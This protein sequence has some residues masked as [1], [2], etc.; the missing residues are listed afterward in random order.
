MKKG[1]GIILYLLF[2]GGLQAQQYIIR[3]DLAG[4]NVKYLQVKKRGD[5]A[6][7]SIIRFSQTNQ[8]NLQLVNSANSYRREITYINRVETPEAVI[9]PG[10][11]STPMK[12]TEAGLPFLDTKTMKTGDIFK[13]ANDNKG[14]E[15][16]AETDQQ[17]VLQQEFV[18][19]YNNFATAYESW[20]Q[21]FYF[22]QNCEVLWKDLAGLRYDMQFPAEEIKKTARKK[23]Q[24]VFPGINDNPAA[25]LSAANTMNP[26]T[27]AAAVKTSYKALTDAHSLFK[28]FDVKSGF[29][30]SLVSSAT[31]K[32]YAVSNA[33]AVKNVDDVVGRITNLYRQIVNDN[34][35]YMTPLNVNRNTIMAEIRFTPVIDSVTATALNISSKDTIK[36]WIPIYKKEPLRFR[37]T[38]GFSFVSYAENRWH[39]YVR[40]D[41]VVARETADQF[42]PV[43]VTYLHF[44]SPRDKGFRWGGSFGAGL[45]VGGDN[46]KL[47]LMLGLS[48]FLGKNDPV[49]ITA[50]VCGTQL[51]KL[52][53]LKVGDKINAAELSDRNYSSVYRVGYFIS[54]TFNPGSL[55]LNN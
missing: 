48:T 27:L 38:F 41:S 17:K 44:Y 37:N 14:F 3:Y 26:S 40:P 46:T 8:V 54:L 1:Y 25:I 15:I 4:E 11:G 55:N 39:Y 29:A 19:R 23:T 42:Q 5:T 20:Q 32:M 35:T 51:K 28:E 6:E 53:G 49:C 12:T 52:S 30:D 45:P 9:I 10:L 24:A 16:L 36:R 33:T 50:G 21:A 18:N 2:C 47:N 34:Y 7:A 43:I 22:E 13:K 31:K